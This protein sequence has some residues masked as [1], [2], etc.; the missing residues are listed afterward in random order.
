MIQVT[1]R[2]HRTRVDTWITFSSTT[3]NNASLQRCWHATMQVA[4]LCLFQFWTITFGT[5]FAMSILLSLM[6]VCRRYMLW[7]SDSG[8]IYR[9]RKR[10]SPILPFRASVR[11]QH[12]LTLR[13]TLSTM[14]PS[15]SALIMP[16]SKTSLQ[17]PEQDVRRASTWNLDVQLWP[18]PTNA[19]PKEFERSNVVRKNHIAWGEWCDLSVMNTL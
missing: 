17:E 16:S 2:T 4:W 12:P 13:R 18:W 6:F 1:F 7:L 5:Y 19:I 3:A 9:V 15:F 8:T 11:Q 10:H 14:R